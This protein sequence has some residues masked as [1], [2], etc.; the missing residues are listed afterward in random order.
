MEQ[1]LRPGR[2]PADGACPALLESVLEGVEL[3]LQVGGARPRKRV[4]LGRL[5]E[6]SL[7]SLER[8]GPRRRRRRRR[9]L[10]GLLLLLL[11]LLLP[12]RTTCWRIFG[13]RVCCG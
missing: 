2:W 5:C 8:R 1:R 10:V 13:G 6:K 12:H 9:L 4:L 3:V 11:R 7:K